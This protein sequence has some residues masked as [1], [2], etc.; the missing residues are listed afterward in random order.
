MD[1]VLSA[2]RLAIEALGG[3]KSV[4]SRLWPDND[5]ERACIKLNNCLEPGRAE[6]LKPQQVFLI[7]RW[8]R[9]AEYHA[10]AEKLMDLAGYVVRPKVSNGELSEL[11]RRLNESQAR[12]L[13]LMRQL[14]EKGE[15]S[16]RLRVVR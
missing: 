1:E 11:K 4:G 12:N 2:I 8:A 16:R 3:A 5:P 13:E 9:D 10:G 15:V 14:A 7:L 6:R